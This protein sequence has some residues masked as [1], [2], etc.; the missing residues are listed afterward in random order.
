MT[1]VPFLIKN[2]NLFKEIAYN[3]I[4]LLIAGCRCGEKKTSRIVGGTE[5]NPVRNIYFKMKKK[6]SF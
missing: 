1:K 4:Y 3:I 6:E 5:V 2:F